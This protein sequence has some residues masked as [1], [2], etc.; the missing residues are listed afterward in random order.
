VSSLSQGE[1]RVISACVRAASLLTEYGRKIEGLEFNYQN[2]SLLDS[3]PKFSI[4]AFKDAPLHPLWAV[5]LD[6][7]AAEK[8]AFLPNTAPESSQLPLGWFSYI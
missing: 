1:P 8:P 4:Y 6:I 2:N 7:L 3:V 5:C